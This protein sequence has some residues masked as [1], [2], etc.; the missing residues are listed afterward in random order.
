M[1]PGCNT[2]RYTQGVTQGGIPQR[3]GTSGWVCTS[4]CVYLPG[5]IPVSL[6]GYILPGLSP[7]LCRG[8]FC[9]GIIASLPPVSLLAD[10]L[11]PGVIPV[12]LLADVCT[13]LTPVSLLVLL[14]RSWA[15]FPHN[16]EHSRFRPRTKVSQ[17]GKLIMCWNDRNVE[18]AGGNVIN[19][20]PRINHKHRGNRAGMH[21]KPATESTSAQGLSKLQTLLIS[22]QN[23]N[24]RCFSLSDRNRPLSGSWPHLL[25]PDDGK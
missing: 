24:S 10:V 1:Y 20:E 22:D 11:H 15:L 18:Q 5:F 19:V 9:S 12:S 4:G 25:V 23:C 6:L 17:N 8:A 7:S 3:D 2:R 21:K 16:G 13:L 14:L